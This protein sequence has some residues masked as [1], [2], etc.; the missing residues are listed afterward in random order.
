MLPGA[1]SSARA[2]ECRV[3]PRESAGPFTA[4]GRNGPDLLAEP[5]MQRSDIR[6]DLNGSH[7]QPGVPLELTMQIV[8]ADN[9]CRPLVGAAV[10]LW[11]CNANGDYSAYAGMGQLDQR[12]RSFLRGVQIT[13]DTGRVTFQSI[14]PGRY[15]G[16]ATHIH[17]QVFADQTLGRLLKTSQLAFDDA[18]NRSV[19][20]AASDYRD[21]AATAEV[22]NARDGLFRDGVE[23]QL[24]TLI[25]DPETGY[26]ANITAAIS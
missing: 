24:L 17:V 23:D 21:S 12:G 4:N 5:A 13:N 7:V 20:A 6:G 3:L 1:T 2:S 11:H 10:Y 14:Y 22:S 8:D 25:G 15:P 26:R 18:T 16:R 19:Y 9:G